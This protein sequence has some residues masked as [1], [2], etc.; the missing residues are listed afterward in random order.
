[1][2]YIPLAIGFVAAFAGFLYLNWP[3]AAPE[4]AAAHTPAAATRVATPPAQTPAQ[5]AVTA[6]PAPAGRK[7]SSTAP[8]M[9]APAPTRPAV[10]TAQGIDSDRPWDDEIEDLFSFL[11]LSGPESRELFA[12]LDNLPA[13]QRAETIAELE[14]SV[15]EESIQAYESFH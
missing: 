15:D 7:V 8:A 10:R 5:Q 6:A 13:D 11:N 14:A 12:Y 4:P 1:M 2:K 9:P 3:A